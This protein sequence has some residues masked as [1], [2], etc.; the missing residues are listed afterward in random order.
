MTKHIVTIA[1][2]LMPALMTVA[3]MKTP[4]SPTNPTT[5]T[6]TVYIDAAEAVLIGCEAAAPLAGPVGT[7][8]GQACPPFV[9]GVLDIIESNGT[10]AT[11]QALLTTVQNE[12]AAV[13][14]ASA[15]NYVAAFFNAA[16]G[17]VNLLINGPLSNG[18]APPSVTPG[19][20]KL[21]DGVQV[22]KVDNTLHPR[23]KLTAAEKARIKALRKRA[24]KIKP[25][26]SGGR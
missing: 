10:A 1:L 25:T 17:I 12:I 18:S 21:A 23:P 4:T 11:L 22:L 13:P 2:C 26:V 16:K 7:L 15:N 5:P 14:G 3:C 8:I 6:N 24:T 19:V 9:N 20:Y